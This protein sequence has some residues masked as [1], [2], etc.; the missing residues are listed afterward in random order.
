[1]EETKKKPD[2][3]STF[4]S[5]DTE[6]FIDIHFYRPIGYQWALFF[7][8]LGVSPNSITIASIFIGI[9]AGICF[10]YQNLTINT[11]GM[12]LLIWA[13]TYDSADG[14]LARMTGNKTPLGRMLDGGAG[15]LWFISIYA[16][17]CLRLTP[18]W[19]IWIWI[20]GAITGFFHSKQ[21]S[22]ADY[23]R[24]I[25]LLFLK[26]KAG[27]EL[28]YSPALKEKVKIMSW[29]KDHIFKA[30]EIFYTNYTS[31]QEALSPKFQ[32]MMNII[33]TKYQDEAPDWFCKAFREKSLP[34]MKYTNMLSFNTRVIALFV[35]LFIDMPWLYFL[36]EMTVLNAMLI[37]MV[38]THEHFCAQ[39]TKELKTKSDK[40][41]SNQ[42]R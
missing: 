31:G 37:Y 30:F 18:Q 2:I 33:R 36:F 1:M 9:A 13:N 34:M 19:G 12:L 42:T 23:Y 28:A 21:A 5:L 29:R 3:T 26:G 22:M 10:Y 6:E 39:F 11:I 20:L 40:I 17:I 14:Q 16:A 8:K 38:F 35:S 4:K 25:H 27:S 32:K 7:N 41:C 24:N 15:D